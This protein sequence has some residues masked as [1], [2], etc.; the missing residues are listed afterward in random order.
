[1]SF[2][3]IDD[4]ID[5]VAS[6]ASTYGVLSMARRVRDRWRHSPLAPQGVCTFCELSVPLVARLAEL[7]L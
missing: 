2:D 6:V 3:L 4:A 1:M 7:K 5:G